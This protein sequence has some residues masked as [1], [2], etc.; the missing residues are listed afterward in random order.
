VSIGEDDK[1][2]LGPPRSSTRANHKAHQVQVHQLTPIRE[3]DADDRSP[4][5]AVIP[6]KDVSKATRS[7]ANKSSPVKLSSSH[8]ELHSGLT[9][10][11]GILTLDDE[12]HSLHKTKGKGR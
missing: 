7:I 2:S 6:Q 8:K 9:P 11:L 10:E 12:V 4:E 1:S 3:E 5:K